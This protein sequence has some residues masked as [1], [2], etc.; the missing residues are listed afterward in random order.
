MIGTVPPSTDQAAPVTFEARSEQRNTIAAAISSSVPKR[1][2]GILSRC[3]SSASSRVMPLRLGHLVGQA[4]L[5]HP[6]RRVHG[7]RRDRVHEHALARPG[8]GEHAASDS[9]AALVTE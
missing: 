6:Q 5:G 2:S 7:A 4:A 3:A 1:P 9:C 8:V